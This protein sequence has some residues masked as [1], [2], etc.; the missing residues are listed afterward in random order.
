VANG[1]GTT[2]HVQLGG[3]YYLL[4]PGSYVKSAAPQFGARF[5][6]GDPDFNNLSMWQHWAQRCLVGGMDAPEFADDAMYDQGVGVD[7]SVHERVSLARDLSRGAGAN[8]TLGGTA[9]RRRFFVYGDALYC[10]TLPGDTVASVLWK[11]NGTTDAWDLV[12]TFGWT[13]HSVAV[14]DGK[15]FL[16]GRSLDKL[17]PKLYW[18]TGA[19]GSWTVVANPAGVGAFHVSAMR[20][21]Q[22]KLYVAYGIYVWR[23]KDDETWDGNTVFYKTNA[24]SDANSVVTFEP[25]LGFLYFL[26]DNGHVH[27]SDGNSTF[28]IWQ[29]DGQTKGIALRSF[30]GRLFVATFEYTSVADVGYGVLYQMT[31]SAMTQLKRWG[32]DGEACSLGSLVAYDRHLFYGASNLLGIRAGFGVAVYDPVEDAHSII[33]SN[34][35]TVTYAR[36]AAPYLAYMVDDVFFWQGLMWA[37]V[38]GHGIFRTSYKT[39]D[40]FTTARYDVTSAGGAPGATNGGW[41]TTSTYDAGTPGLRKLWRKVILDYELPVAACSITLEYS[42]DNGVSWVLQGTASQTNG[43]TLATRERMEFFLQNKIGVSIKLRL[44]LRSTDPTKTPVLHGFVVS[45]LPL[46]EPNW[47]WS[48]TIVLAAKQALLD[49]TTATVDTEAELLFLRDMYRT[50]ALVAF[51][52]VEGEAWASGGEPGVLVYDLREWLPDMTQPLEGEVT[53]TLIE[54]VETY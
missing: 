45:Y 49:G 17:T 25:H 52:D 33:A 21:F 16:G 31:G 50:K 7:T 15:V 47:Q 53:L 3:H 51:T 36:G 22:Q 41:F 12:F 48:F 28:D 44:T 18:S 32:K 10:V 20:V 46:V 54:A 35:D 8:W 9:Y 14:F 19:L 43:A 29:W 6:T 39:R 5:T 11:Y 30:D 13:V 38:R 26:S 2:H 27:R 37:S 34:G 40:R 42:L 1:V 24:T 23:L 4:K